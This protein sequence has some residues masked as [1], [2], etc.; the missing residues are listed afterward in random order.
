MILGVLV[1]LGLSWWRLDVLGE[2]W[3]RFWAVLSGS[4]VPSWHPK[5][6]QDDQK[7]NIQIDHFLM[8]LGIDFWMDVVRFWFQNGTKLA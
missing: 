4:W 1:A 8:A 5:W 3:K 7:V 2:S 6:S